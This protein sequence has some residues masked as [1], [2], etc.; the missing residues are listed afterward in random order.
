MNSTFDRINNWAKNSLM[1]KLIV[2]AFIILL[3]LI[4]SILVEDLIR[5]RRNLRDEAQREIASKFGGEQTIGGPVLSVPYEH[6]VTVETEDG[7]RRSIRT[8]YAHFLPTAIDIQGGLVPEERRRGIFTAVLYNTD[9]TVRGH[10]GGLNVEAL[11]LPDGALRWE[12]ALFTVGISDMTGVSAEITVEFNGE[13]YRMGPGTVTK[14]V[15]TSGANVPVTITG[16]EERMEF[17][18]DLDLNGSA[19][20]YFR[21]FGATTDVNLESAWPDPSFDGT[22]LPTDHEVTDTKFAA[23]WT[24]LQLNRNYP[25][26]GVGAYTPRL[27]SN[28]FSQYS[29]RD[30]DGIGGYTDDR[31]GV[32]LLLPVDEYSKIY[33]STNYSVLF[34]IITFL[35][36]FFIEVLNR[37]RV[38]PIQYILIG[39]AVLLFY[40]LL[41]SISEHQY[42]DVAYFISAAA[43]TALIT[44]YAAAVLRNVRLTALVG[45]LLVVL[46]VFFYSLLQ[47]QDYALLIGSLG[48]LIILGLVMYLT[49]NVDWYGIGSRDLD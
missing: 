31:F 43:I 24:V 15:F 10:F 49:R 5:Q 26:Q 18:F 35:T 44:G 14:D 1:L 45:G 13:G 33:R 6:P 16:A 47:L 38:H 23:H 3:L 41:L 48:L 29:Y 12:D 32:K 19:G 7:P 34:I 30:L 4:P 39:A 17:R 11:N 42:F 21:P 22:F 9:L 8:G 2:I 40:V 27:E 20:L 46:Y 28:N 25:Q 37:R 36:F